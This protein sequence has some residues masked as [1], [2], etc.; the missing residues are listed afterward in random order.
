MGKVADVG[1]RHDRHAGAMI[2]GVIRKLSLLL[3]L[4]AFAWLAMSVVALVDGWHHIV[5]L[6]L[7]VLGLP[8]VV[9]QIASWL[10]SERR[11]P[12]H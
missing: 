3:L 7:F 4:S 2:S 10:R 9:V 11:K 12:H 8:W 5:V 1:E 6:A